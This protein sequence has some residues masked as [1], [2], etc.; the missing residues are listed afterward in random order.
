MDLQFY[1]AN[2]VTLSVGGVRVVV[3]D[4]MTA[5]GGKVVAKA[6]DIVLYTQQQHDLPPKGTKLVIDQPGEY[7]VSDISIY[8]IQMRAHM[9]EEK[10]RTATMY[11]IIAKDVRVLV[12]GHVYPKFKENVLEALGA[13]DV[14]VVPVGGNGYTL[15]PVGA[16]QLV[17]AVEPKVVVPTYYEDSSLSYPMPAQP[18][19]QALKGLGMEPREKTSKLKVKAGEGEPTTQLV[20][21]ER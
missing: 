8:G 10:Q 2:C 3:D 4:T 6:G 20:V 7:E 15:D 17:K 16:L 19:E 5:M 13:I 21:V 12:V 1:G 11:K 14:M 9:D 18:L